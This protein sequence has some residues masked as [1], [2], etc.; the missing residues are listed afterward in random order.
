MSGHSK[1]STIKRKKAVIDSQRGKIFSK[2]VREIIMA[3]RIG[4]ADPESN[5]RLRL[6]LQKAKAANMP[7]DNIKRAIQK[8]SGGGEGADLEEIV[9]EAYGPYGVALLID[10]LTDNKIRTISNVKN[11]LSKAG[12]S[13]AT[14]GAVSYLFERKGLILFEPGASEDHV[15]EIATEAGADDVVLHDDGSIEVT[16]ALTAFIGVKDAFD[17]VSLVYED[18]ELTYMAGTSVNLTFEQAEKILKLVDK[19]EDDDDVQG[20]YGNHDIPADVMAR[21][22]G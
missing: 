16:T 21:L 7:N 4:G 11:I 14:K 19:L 17:A 6:V 18:A 5:A 13:M 3:A 10:T 15:M 20:V 2:I 8:G 9:F 1:W 22:E 12:G